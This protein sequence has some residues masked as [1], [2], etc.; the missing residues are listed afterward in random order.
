MEMTMGKSGKTP[1]PPP[2]RAAP[3]KQPSDRSTSLAGKVLGGKR[4]TRDQVETLAAAVLS[5]DPKKG[6]R[7][8]K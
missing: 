3:P 2:R 8:K 1:P 6:P 7:G 4:A 5:L